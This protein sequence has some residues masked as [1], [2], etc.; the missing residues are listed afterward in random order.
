MRATRLQGVQGMEHSGRFVYIIQSVGKPDRH[1]VGLTCDVALRLREH[2][3]GHS[4]HTA[5]HRPWRLVAYA[6]FVDA[7]LAQR[8]VKDLKTLSAR[9][10]VRRY[11]A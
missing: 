3:Q 8:V 9:G 4:P 7:A 1:Y 2:N 5:K 10:L 11:L 6:G